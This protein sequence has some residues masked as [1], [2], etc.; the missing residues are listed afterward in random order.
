MQGFQPYKNGILEWN[1]IVFKNTPR[2]Y[3]IHQIPTTQYILY[4]YCIV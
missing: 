4:T 1:A 2:T 3:Y